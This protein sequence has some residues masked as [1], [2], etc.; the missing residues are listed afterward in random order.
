MTP[1]GT[2]LCKTEPVNSSSLHLTILA[3]PPPHP[4]PHLTL[5]TEPS[6]TQAIKMLSVDSLTI[7]KLGF[8]IIYY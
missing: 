7:M 8:Y 6:K 3:L 1:C 5:L 4:L 2:L